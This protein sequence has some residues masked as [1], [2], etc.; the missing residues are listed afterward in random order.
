[1]DKMNT[2]I[3]CRVR[4]Y[5]YTTEIKKTCPTLYVGHV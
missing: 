2:N 4:F 5:I 3:L 1:M